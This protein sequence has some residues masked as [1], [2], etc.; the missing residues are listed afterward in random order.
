MKNKKNGIL[1]AG[2][3]TALMSTTA[4][5]TVEQEC[6]NDCAQT[7]NNHY[8][9]DEIKVP[10]LD[11]IMERISYQRLLDQSI[12]NEDFK[13]NAII[14]KGNFDEIAK[15]N[16][17]TKNQFIKIFV[18]FVSEHKKGIAEQ[19]TNKPFERVNSHTIELPTPKDTVEPVMPEA[20]TL[21]EELKDP[22]QSAIDANNFL[23]SNIEQ[24]NSSKYQLETGVKS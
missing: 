24:S 4:L 14:L 9:F 15:D 2:M 1:I 10:T 8:D 5:A 3:L 23:K 6:D 11:Q 16:H 13:E 22:S 18:K 19:S 17:L 7:S 12:T 21:I 20:P